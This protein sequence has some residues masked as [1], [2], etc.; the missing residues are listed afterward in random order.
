MRKIFQYLFLTVVVSTSCQEGYSGFPGTVK[1]D[2]RLITDWIGVHLRVIRNT[3]GITHV[4]YSRHFAYTGVAFYESLVRSAPQYKSV[5]SRLNG[6]V[7]MPVSPK[8]NP[9]FYPAAANSA[10]ATMLRFFY[11]AKPENIASIDSLEQVYTKKFMAVENKMYDLNASVDFGKQVAET[12]IAWSK[13]DGAADANI[14]YTLMGEGYW[15]PT[16]AGFAAANMPGWGNNKPILP[17]SITGTIPGAPLAFSKDPGTA[18]HTMVKEVYD[19]S[20]SLTETQKAIALFWDDA[21]NGKYVTA[22]GHWFSILKQVLEKEKTPLM[23]GA[24]AYLRLGVTMHDAAISCWKTKFTYHLL[25]PVTYVRKYMG[26]SNWSPLISTPPHPEYSAAHATIS[27]SAGFALASVLGKNYS[28]TDHTYDDIGMGSRSFSSF[29]AAG[30]EAGLSRLYGGI[31]YRPS[32]E[33]GTTQG[34]KVGANVVSLL[35]TH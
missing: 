26:Y 9:I 5:A 11:P 2:S 19:V 3:T 1:N 25:R 24:E 32:I 6:N 27:A 20:Q 13:Q 35:R 29:E 4:A 28:F 12:I 33:T 34:K 15:E 14:P 23:K 18:F 8:A 10:M 31:H 21:P 22:F 7:V 16:A 17:G 30:E